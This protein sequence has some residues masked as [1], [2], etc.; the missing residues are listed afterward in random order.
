MSWLTL[1]LASGAGFFS[2][3]AFVLAAVALVLPR[4]HWARGLAWVFA[5][6]GVLLVAL[7]ATPLPWWAYA[8]GAV[9]LLVALL[10]NTLRPRTRTGLLSSVAAVVA[11]VTIVT[12]EGRHHLRQDVS[13]AS[14][15]TLYV[16]GDSLSAGVGTESAPTWP[17]VIRSQHGIDVVNFSRDGATVASAL[18][19]LDRHPPIGGGLV[20][21]E[22]G[23]NDQFGRTP[24][25]EFEANLAALLSRV[26]GPGRVVVMFELPLLPFNNAYG[27]VQRRLAAEH[28]VVLIPKRVLV[29]IVSPAGATTDGIHLTA[30]GHRQ[31]AER[32]WTIVGPALPPP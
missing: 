15:R 4:R 2:G 19:E 13:A 17:A 28:G 5:S 20:L 22:I 23:G 29:H 10:V 1:H 27:Q 32:V 26:A 25:A 8:S 16:I 11:C 24:T 6:V 30:E 14:A 3:M 31:M 9:L 21:L 18:R 12:A 7:S